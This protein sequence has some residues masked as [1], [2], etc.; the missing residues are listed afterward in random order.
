M[1][2]KEEARK[3][4]DNFLKEKPH[5]A[6]RG[7]RV[8]QTPHTG[9]NVHTTWYRVPRGPRGGL[10]PPQKIISA[11]HGYTWFSAKTGDLIMRKVTGRGLPQYHTFVVLPHHEDLTYCNECRAQ[12]TLRE[13]LEGLN[14][15]IDQG[16]LS[17]EEQVEMERAVWYLQDQIERAGVSKE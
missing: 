7:V 4:A 17:P 3:V 15:R 10:R 14:W 6:N 5:L 11:N 1:A 9:Y 13:K 8:G 16:Y 12:F 2:T